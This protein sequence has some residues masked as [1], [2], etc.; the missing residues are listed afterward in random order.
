[1]RTPSYTDAH[2]E[3]DAD[4]QD[5]FEELSRMESGPLPVAPPGP[6]TA[7]SASDGQP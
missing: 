1:M 3:D 6:T 7:T 5:T 4:T 2:P